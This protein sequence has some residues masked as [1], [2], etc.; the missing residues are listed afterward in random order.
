MT[1]A[2][3]SS[4]SS[5][6][7]LAVVAETP[8]LRRWLTVKARLGRYDARMC[9]YYDVD[10]RVTPACQ[11]AICRAYAAGLVPTSTTGGRHSQFSFHKQRDGYGRGRA[12][13]IGNRRSL[14]GTA[15]GIQ[16]LATFQRKEFWRAANGK[17]RPRPIELIGPRND[18]IILR[19]QATSLTEGD[20]LEQQHDDHVHEAY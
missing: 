10:P 9:A 20:A 18:R 2:T 8:R 6:R 12:V 7:R 11:K 3:C 5:D 1:R 15:K 17:L 13:D 14:A 19:G 16:R 4:S